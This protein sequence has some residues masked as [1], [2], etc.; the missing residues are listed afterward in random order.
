MRLKKA[1]FVVYMSVSALA[2]MVM[3]FLPSYYLELRPAN[4]Q[5]AVPFVVDCYFARAYAHNA[6][7]NVCHVYDF[8]HACVQLLY[9]INRGLCGPQ[10]AAVGESFGD[11]AVQLDLYYL[12]LV[13]SMYGIL[14]IIL[15]FYL[16]RTYDGLLVVAKLAY[17]IAIAMS[18]LIVRN[19]FNVIN[20]L[21]TGNANNNQRVQWGWGFLMAVVYPLLSF[22][23]HD[24][25]GLYV[26]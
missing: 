1:Y 21:D 24:T 22:A 6:S 2:N 3:F 14:G 9:N 11:Y 15:L 16:I 17:L 4:D 25:I 7:G 12:L 26:E 5:F 19:T 10:Y 20:Q 18:L 8:N 13:S 23:V